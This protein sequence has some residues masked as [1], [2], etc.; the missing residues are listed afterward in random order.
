MVVQCMNDT[1]YDE[2]SSNVGYSSGLEGGCQLI[3]I[4]S[5]QF[6]IFLQEQ[7]AKRYKNILVTVTTTTILPFHKTA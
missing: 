2:D 3:T 6:K 7:S 5:T 1:T 4:C